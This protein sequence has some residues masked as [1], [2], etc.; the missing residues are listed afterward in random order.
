MGRTPQA[1]SRSR[2][3]QRAGGRRQVGRRSAPGIGANPPPRRCARRAPSPVAARFTSSAGGVVGPARPKLSGQLPGDAQ[4]RERIGPVGRDVHLE[5][6]VADPELRHDVD[7]GRVAEATESRF[8]HLSRRCPARARCTA[9]P[10]TSRPRTSRASS[11]RPPGSRAP[12]GAQATRLPGGGTFAAPQTTS[13]SRAAGAHAHQAQLVRPG[14]RADA[15]HLGHQHAGQLLAAR[16]DPLHLE[17]D[18][19]QDLGGGRPRPAAAR[20]GRQQLA[21]ASSARPSRQRPARL[22]LTQ[23]TQVVLVE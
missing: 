23:E 18:P 11:V 14:V 3:R 7:A 8:R 4:V 22:E 2:M 15:Q 6:V 16:L 13:S 5:D 12:G 17:P 19:G 20:F 10:E 9:C 21:A 1:A